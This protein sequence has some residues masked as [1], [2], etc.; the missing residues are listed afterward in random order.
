[1]L[2]PFAAAFGGQQRIILAA[3]ID[4]EERLPTLPIVAGC[5]GQRIS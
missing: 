4:A 5:A 3:D 1:M 2:Q